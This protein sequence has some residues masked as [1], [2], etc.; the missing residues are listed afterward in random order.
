MPIC[1]QKMQI[2][3]SQ[4]NLTLINLSQALFT[5]FQC[6]KEIKSSSRDQFWWIFQLS[7][8]ILSHLL[9][10]LTCDQAF[11][12]VCLFVV[13]FKNLIAGKR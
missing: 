3:T 4:M 1:I 8:C 13:V 5:Y 2:V 7:L 9:E 10:E 12:C 6:A 11:C